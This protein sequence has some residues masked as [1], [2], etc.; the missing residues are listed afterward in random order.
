MDPPLASQRGAD[1]AQHARHVGSAS[2]IH[3]ESGILRDHLLS[4][5]VDACQLGGDHGNRFVLIVTETSSHCE[6]IIFC[7]HLLVSEQLRVLWTHA[8]PGTSSRVATLNE[9]VLVVSTDGV[10]F[11]L[12]MDEDTGAFPFC[13]LAYPAHIPLSATHIE[14]LLAA[15][16]DPLSPEMRLTKWILV[17]KSR[18]VESPSPQTDT[19]ACASKTDA[20]ERN[21]DKDTQEAVHVQTPIGVFSV[22][23][24]LTETIATLRATFSKAHG[25]PLEAVRAWSIDSTRTCELQLEDETLLGDLDVK[26]TP[27]QVQEGEDGPERL[28]E[29][30]REKGKLYVDTGKA[31][32]KKKTPKDTFTKNPRSEEEVFAKIFL[33]VDIPTPHLDEMR[34]ELEQLRQIVQSNSLPSPAGWKQAPLSF[35]G[36]MSHGGKVELAACFAAT[37]LLN[38]PALVSVAIIA[39]YVRVRAALCHPGAEKCNNAEPLPAPAPNMGIILPNDKDI[40]LRNEIFREVSLWES[41]DRTTKLLHSIGPRNAARHGTFLETRTQKTP[42]GPIKSAVAGECGMIAEIVSSTIVYAV[43]LTKRACI[44]SAYTTEVACDNFVSGFFTMDQTKTPSSALSLEF[45]GVVCLR[46]IYV[47]LHA[48]LP[49]RLATFYA[50]HRLR[51]VTYR[52][53]LKLRNEQGQLVQTCVKEVCV[54]AKPG[55]DT[56]VAPHF[57]RRAQTQLWSKEQLHGP[58]TKQLVSESTEMAKEEGEP[59]TAE[60]TESPYNGSWCAKVWNNEVRTVDIYIESAGKG[61]LCDVSGICTLVRV[62]PNGWPRTAEHEAQYYDTRPGVDIIDWIDPQRAL[63]DTEAEFCQP[64]FPQEDLFL[65][66]DRADNAERVNLL[67]RKILVSSCVGSIL[68]GELWKRQSSEMGVPF[69]PPKLRSESLLA[70]LEK[71]HQVNDVSAH[72]LHMFFDYFVHRSER[73]V[74]ESDW[75]RYVGVLC[76]LGEELVKVR[77][78]DPNAYHKMLCSHFFSKDSGSHELFSRRVYE[79]A[80]DFPGWTPLPLLWPKKTAVDPFTAQRRV[81]SSQNVSWRHIF[82]EPAEYAVEISYSLGNTLGNDDTMNLHSIMNAEANQVWDSLRRA[83]GLEGQG[84]LPVPRCD[85]NA[86]PCEKESLTT[87]AASLVFRNPCSKELSPDRGAQI[88][89]HCNLPLKPKSTSLVRWELVGTP[90][91]GDI[92]TFSEAASSLRCLQNLY[93][94]ASRNLRAHVENAAAFGS[95]DPLAEMRVIWRANDGNI[96]NDEDDPSS[97]SAL[98]IARLRLCAGEVFKFTMKEIGTRHLENEQIMSLLRSFVFFGSSQNL[99]R[100][101]AKLLSNRLEMQPHLIGDILSSEAEQHPV[102]DGNWIKFS[103]ASALF[104]VIPGDGWTE[105]KFAAL[106][107]VLLAV[108]LFLKRALPLHAV[109]SVLRDILESNIG[110]FL[111]SRVTRVKSPT[112]SEGVH[113]SNFRKITQITLRLFA[114]IHSGLPYC[115]LIADEDIS[116]SLLNMMVAEDGYVPETLTKMAYQAPVSRRVMEA[117][118]SPR[119]ARFPI[120]AETLRAIVRYASTSVDDAVCWT[121]TLSILRRLKT[122]AV[123]EIFSLDL[124]LAIRQ[125]LLVSDT[126]EDTLKLAFRLREY[127]LELSGKVGASGNP[128][129]AADGNDPC[130]HE[131]SADVVQAEKHGETVTVETKRGET[132]DNAR[133]AAQDQDLLSM[134]AHC[135]DILLDPL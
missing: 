26:L 53:T 81:L 74:P 87:A 30:Q 106:I 73:Y 20:E 93:T 94:A 45:T 110:L 47:E 44:L 66:K 76:N 51:S 40:L 11:I 15:L 9:S 1:A 46:E 29:H 128:P 95:N 12:H 68:A 114:R 27:R 117:I 18:P 63:D 132:A 124:R 134:S 32:N 16:S 97:V 33:D 92:R 14:R 135:D 83:L 55:E 88:K 67:P 21:N 28:Q 43:S 61:D 36:L 79:L 78:E 25:L 84:L 57:H 112:K 42:G 80:D 41:A 54:A 8:L 111:R 5:V 58:P 10:Q 23:L 85:D 115:S 19:E 122:S 104:N 118:A 64:L 99:S 107:S 89:L 38:A 39:E 13:G 31:E 50:S 127:W 91:K 98:A 2:V 75:H 60:D 56:L 86:E 120:S 77:N 116:E 17:Q 105:T 6:W 119:H 35:N 108:E 125:H 72:S 82:S 100:D 34:T 62:T 71:I 133:D 126:V 7:E 102:G 109:T 123:A 3:D 70:T 101:C 131:S 103:S 48:S 49:A 52:I 69:P 121:L 37:D 96:D 22:P 130:K 59:A 113:H 4:Q 65:I 90:S 129:F 24:G